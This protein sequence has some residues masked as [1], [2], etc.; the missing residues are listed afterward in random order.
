MISTISLGFCINWLSML[1]VS[2]FRRLRVILV[3]NVN[4]SWV[5]FW[6]VIGKVLAWWFTAVVITFWS[7]FMMGF[8]ERS[9]VKED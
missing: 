4:L 8:R 1:K 7:L 9:R 2:A 3:G 6:M 5:R